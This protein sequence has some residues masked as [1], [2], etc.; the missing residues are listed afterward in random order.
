MSTDPV[1]SLDIANDKSQFQGISCFDKI[2]DHASILDKYHPGEQLASFPETWPAFHCLQ[3]SKVGE[4]LVFLER[5]DGK[6]GKK[7]LFVVHRYSSACTCRTVKVPRNLPH[8]SSRLG[9][10]SMS[11][12]IALRMYFIE[13]YVEHWLFNFSHLPSFSCSCEE[14]YFG[15]SCF[16]ILQVTKSWA[17][18]RL[19]PSNMHSCCKRTTECSTLAQFLQQYHWDRR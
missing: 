13:Q 1:P 17:K 2:S 4:N 12:C 19:V 5:K 6:M 11:Y 16:I 10:D 9:D 3:Y 8:I 7:G 15:I 14:R 18:T